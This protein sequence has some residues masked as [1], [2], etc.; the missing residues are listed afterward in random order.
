MNL[1]RCS[2]DLMSKLIEM[3]IRFSHPNALRPWRLH[4]P[5][6]ELANREGDGG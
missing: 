4:V 2:N 1:K 3:L 6:G 5:V